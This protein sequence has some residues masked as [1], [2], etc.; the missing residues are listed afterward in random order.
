[1]KPAAD[2]E[3]EDE[4]PEVQKKQPRGK[5]TNTFGGLWKGEEQLLT[6]NT[7]RTVRSTGVLNQIESDQDS[8]DID[9]EDDSSSDGESSD[10]NVKKKKKKPPVKRGAPA[11]KTTTTTT[12]I[13]TNNSNNNNNNGK[14]TRGRPPTSNTTTT[15][16]SKQ[17]S[18]TAPVAVSKTRGRPPKKI[19]V[20]SSEEEDESEDGEDESDID[21][22]SDEED[23][24]NKKKSN[25]V[26]KK[27]SPPP[28][29]QQLT[30]LKKKAV[31][32]ESESSESEP[33]QS[34]VSESERSES[35]Q[36]D[37]DEENSANGELDLKDMGI[38]E[39]LQEEFTVEK[40]LDTRMQGDDAANQMEQVLVK[41]KGLSYLHCSWVDSN[42]LIQTRSGKARLQRYQQTKQ[43]EAENAAAKRPPKEDY[44]EMMKI[45]KI[46]DKRINSDNETEYYI[47]WRAQTYLNCT[48]ELASDVN[49]EEAVAAFAQF[50]K[51]PSSSELTVP[52]RPAPSGWKEFTASPEY[53]KKGRLLRPYQLQGLNWLS[54]CWYQKRNSI[55]GD[56]MGLGKTVQSVSIIETLRK[57]QGIRGPFLCVAPLTTIPHWKREFES[58]TDQK[59][60]VY[61]DHGQARPIIRDYEFYYTDSKGRTT[62]VTKFNTLITTYEMVISD[63]A[64]LS[65]IHWRY[66]V[67]DEAHRLKN[68]SCKL[69]NEL[70]TYKYDHLLLLTGTPLQNNTQELWSLLNFMEPEKFAHLEEFLEEFGDLKQAEQVTKLQEV[71]RPYLLRRMKENVEK[72]IAPKEETIVEVELTTI[73]KKYYRAIYE[74][75]FTFLRKGGKGNGPSL[76]NIMME[77][78]KCCNH[79]Y[80]IKG[81]EDSETSMLMKNSDAIYHKLIQAS[82][83]LVLIDKLLP[84]LKAGNHKV[85]I[86]SQMVSV[87][88]ILD[89]YLTFRG[90][91]HERIDGSIKAEDRQAAIDR[92]SAPDSDRFVFLLC[93][94]AG[95][96]GINL[97][98]AD[99]VII[100]DSDWNPQNDLQAQ[101]RCHRIGQDKMV[102][103]YRLV[104]RNTYERIM[105]DRASKKL[106]LDRAVLTKINSNGTN[107]APAKEELPDKETIDSLLKFGVY[108]IKE[109]DAASERF[110]E[111]DIDK[112]LDRSTVVKQETV[113]PLASSFSTASFC[114]SNSASNIDVNDPNFWDKFVPE[115]D[116]RSD[117]IMLPR[118]RKNVQRFGFGDESSD[119]DQS[120]YDPDGDEEDTGSVNDFGWTGAERNKFK[121]ALFTFGSGRWDL[122]KSMA[123]LDRWTTDQVRQ[124]GEAF[125]TKSLD[126]PVKAVAPQSEE[127]EAKLS[128]ESLN[129][130]VEQLEPSVFQLYGKE[131]PK[132]TG[133]KMQIESNESNTTTT[134][135][136]TSESKDT[137]PFINDS[138]LSDTKFTEYLTRNSKKIS[139]KLAN[140]AALAQIL[141]VGYRKIVDS[142]GELGDSP[143]SCWKFQEDNDLLVGTYRYGFGE[144]DT[145]RKDKSLCFHKHNYQSSPDSTSNNNTTTDENERVWPS[146]K[147]L[148][149]RFKRILRTME[150]Y[151]KQQVKEKLH[152]MKKMEKEE[153]KKKSD[154]RVEW[155]KREKSDFYKYIVIFGV[156]ETGPNEYSWDLIKEKASLKKKTGDMIERYYFDLLTK[157][158]QTINGNPSSN[159]AAADN[160]DDDKD[161]KDE[162]DGE[163]TISQCKRLVNRIYFLNKLRGKILK[164]PNLTTILDDVSPPHS[165][166]MWYQK[167]VHDI[168]LLQGIAKHGYGQF[169]DICKDKSFPFY[170]IYKNL[171][172]T[173]GKYES[174][175]GEDENSDKKRKRKEQIIDILRLPKDKY[176][177][178]RIDSVIDFVVNPRP[179]HRH[180]VGSSN[181]SKSSS[182]SHAPLRSSY[183][184]MNSSASGIPMTGSFKLGNSLNTSPVLSSSGSGIKNGGRVGSSSSSS[185]S[186]KQITILDFLSPSKDKS[187]GKDKDK[188]KEKEKDKKS[189]ELIN[190]DFD[191]DDDEQIFRKAKRSKKRHSLSSSSSG[192]KKS[193][194]KIAAFGNILHES[195]DEDFK[196]YEL[197]KRANQM[198]K[199]ASTNGSNSNGN[200]SNNSD[201]SSIAKERR[202]SANGKTT[203]TT[204]TTTTSTST[205]ST[206]SPLN[207]VTMSDVLNNNNQPEPNLHESALVRPGSEKST[208][209]FTNMKDQYFSLH[210]YFMPDLSE[211]SKDKFDL[212]IIGELKLTQQSI[213]EIRTFRLVFKNIV[214]RNL[215]FTKVSELSKHNGLHPQSWSYVI[216]SP[217]YMVGNGYFSQLNDFLFKKTNLYDSYLEIG[218]FLGP[219]NYEGYILNLV[220]VIKNA[221]KSGCNIE[222]IRNLIDYYGIQKL[223]NYSSDSYGYTRDLIIFLINFLLDTPSKLG[224]WDII[225]FLLE[226]IVIPE[227]KEDKI[228]FRWDFKRAMAFSVKSGDFKLLNFMT[229]KNRKSPRPSYENEICDVN[230]LDKAASFGKIE[231]IE[232][233]IQNLPVEELK[234]SEMMYYAIKSGH[235]HV[236]RYVFENQLFGKERVDLYYLTYSL[237]FRQIEILKMLAEEYGM[238]ETSN[239]YLM[240][241]YSERGDLEALILLNSFNYWQCTTNA[242]DNA[243]KGH[244]RVVIWLHQN[245]TEGCTKEALSNA[246]SVL[247]VILM[248]VDVVVVEMRLVSCVNDDVGSGGYLAIQFAGYVWSC[249]NRSEKYYDTLGCLTYVACITTIVFSNVNG[250]FTRRALIASLMVLLWSV[251]LG[252]FLYSRMMHHSDNTFQDKRFNGVRD[253]P[254]QLLFYWFA[255][256]TWIIISL[257]PIYIIN[258]NIPLTN[259]SLYTLTFFDYIVC[260]C[261]FVS[262]SI[263]SI[264]DSQK[265]AFNAVPS[266]RGKFINVGLWYYCRHPNYV[267]EMMIHWF[268]YFFCL[269]V[270]TFSQALVALIAPLLV[271]A[272]MTK[273]ASPMLEEQ[274]NIKWKND[275]AYQNYLKSTPRF[276]FNIFK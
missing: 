41:W 63:R 66:L 239:T 169:E 182:S 89:D 164:N 245:R 52:P 14:P 247:V 214:L 77:L 248:I 250:V 117:V 102:K 112:I 5:K 76:L 25:A 213:M 24:K 224:R 7:R 75:N 161:D 60:L 136:N 124:Y 17:S 111:E 152:S 55:L 206:S 256:S 198:G 85:L 91:L 142:I 93:T 222:T 254:I 131:P 237:N 255:Q 2:L 212:E 176:L 157:C 223:I 62:N 159:G 100:F 120:D 13:T 191:S 135:N 259:Q 149:H 49:D 264:A 246:K 86:F 227:D 173:Q 221:I 148:S 80:L 228:Q 260:L 127:G 12:T 53:F 163:L 88:D 95:G 243:S 15:T 90:Y 98:A 217:E 46:L 220:G 106:G 57:T 183:N 205:S 56:E 8:S 236:V 96:M 146:A 188:D 101:A 265:R 44:K 73:Q 216:Y 144:Y 263:E 174:S 202:S 244:L 158:Q 201:E 274:S 71:L 51:M 153:K 132:V 6:S 271:T 180:Y 190:L 109:D 179:S 189:L 126:I 87:L 34:E 177:N 258:N 65:K 178:A 22:I 231:I 232:Y 99:T 28:A 72:S 175:D 29:K 186:K 235:Q 67:I 119:D 137:N 204:T 1:M 172:K 170:D 78:R 35:E 249:L 134:S 145:M 267:G 104:T 58:W 208:C 253:K 118:T 130:Y 273:I 252:W 27:Q 4:A 240:D 48:W 133:D 105:F 70:R 83:K 97:T 196:D 68:K 168:A 9:S 30:R 251:R 33:S 69:T 129:A 261:W 110:Y 50:I 125:I 185:S 200:S 266:N 219:D 138:S 154:I 79:P 81:A 26:V 230:P 121:S 116:T 166:P 108:A 262:I 225:H 192:L 128:V 61:H 107:A 211:I 143:F 210:K 84:K 122:I 150:G 32:V 155:T 162:K 269:P 20:S 114:S 187:S 141:R 151:K 199:R 43:Q 226:Y 36:S 233:L 215:I 238:K 234:R 241:Y 194:D 94:R 156:I 59:V 270:F 207:D 160:K 31:Q 218:N 23:T 37:S 140:M 45:E 276:Y 113:D 39:R 242:M 165:F 268:A 10:D 115:L 193:D 19:V 18:T 40:V 92:F 272:L 103:V 167:G 11:T 47:K 195:D 54:F 16:T 181:S 42:Q 197:L 229:E 139:R 257:I 209:I 171:A 184:G 21:I 275:T 74:K 3:H 147:I 38:D 123:N 203:I 64:Q 82:G